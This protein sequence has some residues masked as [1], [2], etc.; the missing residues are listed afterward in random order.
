M[1]ISELNDDLVVRE[2]LKEMVELFTGLT[3]IVRVNSILAS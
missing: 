1:L 3:P 2:F